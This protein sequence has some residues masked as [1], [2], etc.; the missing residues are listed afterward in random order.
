MKKILV[1][2]GLILTLVVC[3]AFAPVNAATECAHEKVTVLR[4]LDGQDKPTNCTES[5]IAKVKCDACE[6]ELYKKV[7]GNHNV[8]EIVTDATCTEAQKVEA[9]CTLCDYVEASTS[10]GLAPAL[11]H[12]LKVTEFAAT[13]DKNAGTASK[14]TRCDYVEE[15]AAYPEGHEKYEEAIGHKWD[16]GKVVAATCKAGGYT[17]FTCENCE[18]TKKENETE[19]DETAHVKGEVP[20]SVLKEATCTTPGIGK[21]NCEL[22]GEAMGY[23]NIPAQHSYDDFEVTVAAK[24]GVNAKGFLKCVACGEK[25]KEQEIPNTALKHEFVEEVKDATCTTPQVVGLVCKYCKAVDEEQSTELAPALGH[26]YTNDTIV[27]ATCDRPSGVESTCANCGDKKF[28]AFKETDSYYVAPLNHK[29]TVELKAVE[30]TCSK[31][32]LTAGTKCKD[33]GKILKAQET[34]AKNPEKHNE[35]VA[36][37]L[38]AAS[39]NVAG[40]GKYK[41]AD[42][43]KDLGYKSIPAECKGFEFTKVLEEAT[44][45]KEGK[46]LLTC[47]DCG[48]TKEETIKKLA[49][50]YEV[51][52][53]EYKGADKCLKAP[54]TYEVCKDCG[55]LGKVTQTAKAPGHK[56]G[57][58]VVMDANCTEGQRVG[59]FCTVCE[60]AKFEPEVL[61]PA[62]GHTYKKTSTFAATCDKANG[63]IQT[64]SRC[65]DK[66]EVV[67]TS[68][69]KDY[70]APLNH[71]NTKTLAAVAATC[72]ANGLTEGT[73]CKD[74]G[75]ILKAQ[76]KTEI[77]P[78]NHELKLVKTLKA[79]TCTVA[80][81][82]KYEC[83]SCGDTNTTTYQSIAPKHELV[84]TVVKAATC[85]EAGKKEITCKNC[86]YK[87]TETIAK[88]TTHTYNNEPDTFIDATCTS[89]A[90]IG[91]TCTVCGNK[92][93][94]EPVKDSKPLG[95]D[96]VD[97]YVEATCTEAARIELSCSRCDH[98]ETEIVLDET[99]VG[100]YQP[101]LGHKE[102]IV[103]GYAQTC[104]K[105]GKK[106][107][108]KCSRCGI[109]LVAQETIKADK[110][111]H[112]EV[113]VKVLKAATCTVA[114]V[115]KYGCE[116]CKA[117]LGYQSI[118]ASHDKVETVTKAATCKEEGVKTITCKNCDYK[119]TEKIAKL[120]THTWG[121]ITVIE[122]TCTTGQM[123]GRKCTVCGAADADKPVVG[124]KPLGH[125]Y[126]E[127][128]VD[129][130]CTEDSYIAK[131]CSRCNA[132]NE[133]IVLTVEEFG[134]LAVA[135]LGHKEV[136][137][138]GYA[139]TCATDG[140]ED[141][142]KCSRCD[143]V[144]VAQ[145]TIKADG[146][147]HKLSETP[148]KV[149][150]E[151]TCE[152]AG[153]GKFECAY[154][155]P[156]YSVYQAII[157]GHAWDKGTVTKE[158]TCA[159]KGEKTYTC[160]VCEKTKKEDV[161]PLEHTIV[162]GVIDATCTSAA[163]VG[164]I[165]KVCKYEKETI[166]VEGSTPA[167]HNLEEKYVEAT[168][169]EGAYVLKTCKDCKFSEKEY[170]TGAE[171]L[172]H[173][174]EHMVVEGT[175]KVAGFEADVCVNCGD[176]QN[177]VKGE[178]NAEN[179]DFV[180]E[181]VIKAATCTEAGVARVK[182]ADC[183]E[184][185]YAAIS[186]DH[187]FGTEEKVNETGTLVYN[188][189]LVE[190]C[191]AVKVVAYFGTKDVAEGQVF[192]S[193]AKFAELENAK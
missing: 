93:G 136:V 30:A 107:G 138:K 143:K 114:G 21:Y 68:A 62:L 55:A 75:K 20:T 72:V 5:G 142:V 134:D 26:N 179:H 169:E 2:L 184:T 127:V 80:G 10:A 44:C 170:I 155:G 6:E 102:E 13:C 181:K 92:K 160:L 24:C 116:Y 190:G 22:C 54:E 98:V 64:C 141:G 18:G 4:F 100:L 12:D 121:E 192:V 185:T 73:Q 39:C 74:C 159:A 166:E 153:V 109:T 23:Q 7:V 189:C 9:K 110:V 60:S 144:L 51:L 50:N 48:K 133:K 43:G 125:D 52:Q 161:K 58:E 99:F 85:K 182:C 115:G 81:V 42:C 90:M 71:K 174:Y 175:C 178:I 157:D 35:V 59:I 19:V 137:V 66:K 168:C 77:N 118:P 147:S 158:P 82:G 78:S 128:Y 131:S 89:G 149:L 76:E 132:V 129:A 105:D 188:E 148:V 87:A 152:V 140:K 36:S 135:A 70:K 17:L 154:C 11:G 95:H 186:S 47:A 91:F 83:T 15:F 124:S 171:A 32:G 156:E 151:A 69:H 49:H 46:A 29:N 25:T 41:C 40:V 3:C 63:E 162:E 117:D 34:V 122:A 104:S 27:S 56:W 1:S 120:T 14:C 119:A 130:T 164:L 106:D 16:E 79:A 150:K 111:S 33:C 180:A 187:S 86:D 67:Y 112:K 193:L 28:V 165:C 88:L 113:V 139:Q 38:K 177:E 108:A 145:A 96:L 101:A 126:V 97:T 167:A 53:R 8:K 146:T 57:E 31:T 172:S 103:K 183:G 84:T 191:T 123:T 94:N 45:E 37:V 163:K 176:K 65:G 173:K 61:A